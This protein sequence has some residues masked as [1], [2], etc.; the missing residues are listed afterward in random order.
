ML[1]PALCEASGIF[2][3][4]LAGSATIFALFHGTEGFTATGAKV[5]LYLFP[6]VLGV[7][8][9]SHGLRFAFVRGV[10][11]EGRQNSAKPVMVN[12]PNV[13]P[14]YYFNHLHS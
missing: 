13:A 4:L 2:F 6:F 12:L 8:L 3:V 7:V 10:F 5:F 11:L 1:A 9:I 14:R